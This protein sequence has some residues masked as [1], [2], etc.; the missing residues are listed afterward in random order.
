MPKQKIPALEYLRGIS[1]LGVLGIHT[2]A[3]SLSNP[4]TNMHLFALLEICSRFSVPIFF[5]ISAFGLFLHQ[6]LTKPLDYQKF[7]G[8]RIRTV[9]LPYVVW[10]LLYMLYSTWR[11]HDFSLL[12]P[13]NILKSLFFGLASYQLYFLVIL[14]WFYALM[15]LWRKAVCFI[16]QKPI[17]YLSILLIGQI[18]FDYYSSYILHANSTSAFINMLIEYRLNYWVT[19]YIFIF[20][21]GAVCAVQ[22]EKFKM[23]LQN[24]TR[25]VTV[26]FLLSLG[27]L[28]SFYYHLVL[29]KGYSLEES[30]NTAHQLSPFGI[31]YTLG[32]TIFLF[33]V[34][35]SPIPKFLVK[36]LSF[37][38]IHSY[39]IYL[40]HPFA[41]YGLVSYLT[42]HGIIMNAFITIT[43]YAAALGISLVAAIIIKKIS[44]TLPLINYLLTGT[45]KTKYN[46]K[47]GA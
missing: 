18:L 23:F 19:H 43:F 3:Y 1:M 17:R 12:G 44:Q 39:F 22:Y 24:Y 8:R 45:N 32:I 37:L 13:L 25:S 2:G 31:F 7:I 14:L 26:F 29:Q 47:T 30:V 28:L 6:D 5:F 20:L 41:M 21:L 4:H 9:F 36:C 35:S 15:P 42:R 10:S 33:S 38:G 11:S 16:I 40:F 34:L 27:G 46:L